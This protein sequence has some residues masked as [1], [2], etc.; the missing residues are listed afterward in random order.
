[1]PR[2]C[3]SAVDD[4]YNVRRNRSLELRDFILVV[5]LTHPVPSDVSWIGKWSSRFERRKVVR[6]SQSYNIGLNVENLMF[7]APRMVAGEYGDTD[8]VDDPESMAEQGG[9]AQDV[10]GSRSQEFCVPN[11]PQTVAYGSP[12][13]DTSEVST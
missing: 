2:S 6:I 3:K 7:R 10:V 9:P 12:M 8:D 5:S 13:E 4:V 1:V 11:T